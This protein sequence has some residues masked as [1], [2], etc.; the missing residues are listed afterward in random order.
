MRLLAGFGSPPSLT[1]GPAQPDQGDRE[2]DRKQHGKRDPRGAVV[3]DDV[4]AD[5]RG[6]RVTGS[7]STA[8]TASRS[9]VMVILVSVGRGRTPLLRSG[10]PAGLPLM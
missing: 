3:D 10:N 8:I 4:H 7:V 2:H 6:E 5:N 1:L 9:A